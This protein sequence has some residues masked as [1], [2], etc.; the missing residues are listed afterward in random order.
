MSQDSP[1]AF[2]CNKNFSYVNWEPKKDLPQ[3]HLNFS[4]IKK[5][6]AID[7][8]NVGLPIQSP[9]VEISSVLIEKK[10]VI[11]GSLLIAN[12]KKG[13]SKELTPDMEN[14]AK[15]A[16]IAFCILRKF[17]SPEEL[18]LNQETA[19]NDSEKVDSLGDVPSIK[20]RV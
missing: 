4:A 13:C 2:Q 15:T 9:K 7:L 5:E 12:E 1:D 19:I 3:L 8:K 11:E 10:S 6:E 20:L 14:I 18:P 17:V 16:G